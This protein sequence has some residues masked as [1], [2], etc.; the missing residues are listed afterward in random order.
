MRLC[1]MSRLYRIFGIL[2][3]V[4]HYRSGLKLNL[5]SGVDTC[6]LCLLNSDWRKSKRCIARHYCQ[7]MSLL[8]KMGTQ[9]PQSQV[10]IEDL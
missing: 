5:Y 3:N 10:F 1:L 7:F 9:T 6:A 4:S 8:C 2:Q